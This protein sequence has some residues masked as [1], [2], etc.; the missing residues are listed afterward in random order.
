MRIP[1]KYFSLLLLVSLF[2]G[3]SSHDDEGLQTVD[4]PVRIA[5]PTGNM[6]MRAY[7]D[8][9]TYETFQLPRYIYLFL[10]TTHT[11]NGVTTKTVQ[12]PL[13]HTL[14]ADKWEKKLG[15]QTAF[16]VAGTDSLYVY[17]GDIHVMFPQG[18]TSGG[19]YFDRS[20]GELGISEPWD[21]PT[22]AAVE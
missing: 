21:P 19:V 11:H 10:V 6:V 16:Q 14:S 5:I 1:Y 15:A 3:C 13:S 12:R 20:A 9:G 2:V 17:T 4:M 8:P 18:P 7:G 22:M